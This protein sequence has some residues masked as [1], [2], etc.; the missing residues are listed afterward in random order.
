MAVK[1]V[2]IKRK[3]DVDVVVLLESLLEDA[4]IGELQG[5]VV[6]GVT[7]HGD[8]YSGLAGQLLPYAQIGIMECIKLRIMLQ[9][10]EEIQDVIEWMPRR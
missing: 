7:S 10:D 6:A 3:P 4:R 2:E 9:H 1:P 8:V 5:V